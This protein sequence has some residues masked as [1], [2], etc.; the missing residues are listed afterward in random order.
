MAVENPATF[1]AWVE[2]LA[3]VGNVDIQDDFDMVYGR[4]ARPTRF[5]P[6]HGLPGFGSWH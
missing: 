1:N 3:A 2:K 5:F 6:W 4:L